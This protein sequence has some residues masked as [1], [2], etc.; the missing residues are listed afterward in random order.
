MNDTILVAGAFGQ[1][2]R[3][4]TEILLS[5]GR[6]VIAMDLPSDATSAV[7]R[8]LTGAGHPGTPR[9]VYADLGAT[10]ALRRSNFDWM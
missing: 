2:S 7:A 5:R 8:T 3:R 4:C 6:T 1:F 10:T 9:V